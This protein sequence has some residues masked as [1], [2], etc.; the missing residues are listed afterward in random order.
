MKT[1]VFS[2]R[3]YNLGILKRYHSYF[4]RGIGLVSCLLLTTLSAVSQI[5][6]PQSDYQKLLPYI[7]VIDPDPLFVF[8]RDDGENEKAALSAVSPDAESS[9]FAWSIYN[10]DTDTWD[11]LSADT[12]VT[13]SSVSGLDEG[14]YE[15]RITNGS[16][17]D[18]TF[19]AWVMLDRMLVTVDKNADGSTKRYN[20]SCESLVLSAEVETDDYLYYD[21]VTHEEIELQNGFTFIWTSDNSD[22]KIYNATTV[23]SPNSTFNPPVKDTQYV[24]TATDSLGMTV[25]DSVFYET[26]STKASFSVEYYDKINE[27]F[28]TSPSLKDAPLTVRFLNE[29][30]NGAE[31][32]WIFV[33]TAT[34]ADIQSTYTYSVD[35]QPTFIYERA[36][37]EYNPVLISHSIDPLALEG[38]TDT[39]ML[40]SS[41]E[42]VS[43]ALDIPNVFSPNGDG[44]NDYFLFSHQ[45][46][47]QCKLTILDRW[48]KVIYKINIEDIY[49]WDGW[50]GKV[51]NS[52]RDAPEGPYY[53]IIEAVGYDDVEYRDKNII[54]RLKDRQQTGSGSTT[55]SETETT[56]GTYTG[57]VYLFRN[58]GEW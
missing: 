52:D 32:E 16:G 14:G 19:R 44:T 37:E 55:T 26:I 6:A 15:V 25:D 56:G 36:G 46:I 34:I 30:E 29:S 9:T 23:L 33:D 20:Y 22:N 54:D 7:S 42:V 51:L 10:P 17:L 38:C 21:P 1:R 31:F 27:E 11:A 35:D 47:K 50:N 24:L 41:I 18:T 57:W 43:S 5:S 58:E 45:S 28:T 3:R 8:Y 39:F 53:Y 40:E 12:D 4:F 2:L 13:S 49:A 48:G